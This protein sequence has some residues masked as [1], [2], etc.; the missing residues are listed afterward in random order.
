MSIRSLTNG[1]LARRFPEG[2]ARTKKQGELAIDDPSKQ[3]EKKAPDANDAIDVI[4]KYIPTEAIALYI[5]ALPI[6]SSL[7]SAELPSSLN[8]T[9]IHLRSYLIG[10]INIDKMYLILAFSV[11]TAIIV[12][13]SYAGDYNKNKGKWEISKRECWPT[14]WSI[15]S[16]M[17]AF[18][19]WAWAIP[20]PLAEGG[21]VNVSATATFIL[22]AT[23][24]FLPL[25]GQAIA[26]NQES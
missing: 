21:Q 10:Y 26:P 3:N 2:A 18:I 11:L 14:L 15:V 23:S 16:A 7:N 5:A 12:V 19:V 8:T 25:I 9:A 6:L 17:V 4:M 13:L 22:I 1:D 24:I 20:N